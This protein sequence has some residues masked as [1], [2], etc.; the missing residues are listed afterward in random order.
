M[1]FVSLFFCNE[2]MLY[3]L[4]LIF[5]RNQISKERILISTLRILA[6]SLI[7]RVMMKE[8]SFWLQARLIFW[9]CYI[10]SCII[11]YHINECKE[12][13]QLA[14]FFRQKISVQT[15]IQTVL[16]YF[17]L[18]HPPGYDVTYFL[19]KVLTCYNGCV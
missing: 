15:I 5:P 14:N 19:P 11:T 17:H 9:S 12:P 13:K 8:T 18:T 3:F 4:W 7:L 10:Y 16:S 2:N 1:V 6:I